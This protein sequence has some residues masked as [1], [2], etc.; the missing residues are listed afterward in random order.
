MGRDTKYKLAKKIARGGMAE[1]FL[2]SKRN[3]DGFLRICCI[4]RIL[5]HFASEKEFTDMFRDEARLC[6]TLS[7]PNIVQVEDFQE[8]D[9]SWAIVMEFVAGSDLRALLAACE[10]SRK[11][12]SIPMICWIGAEAAR[13]LHYAHTRID[14][15]TGKGLGIVHRD[16]SP[17]NLMV[18]FAGD[19]KVTDFGIAEADSKLNET[20]PGIVKGKYAYMSPEQISAKPVDARTDVFALGV[21]LWEAISMRRL[22][23]SDNDA[24]TIDMVK[25]CKIPSVF[26]YN[27]TEDIHPDLKIIIAKALKKD[28]KERW[29]SIEDFEKALRKFIA[30]QYPNFE[31]LELSKFI[32]SIMA[33]KYDEV[34]ENIKETLMASTHENPEPDVTG[35]AALLKDIKP[36]SILTPKE[37]A[38]VEI[39]ESQLTALE[40]KNGA[41]LLTNVNSQRPQRSILDEE[42]STIPKPQFRSSHGG[43]GVRIG[44][45]AS[46][47]SGFASLARLLLACA[48]IFGLT[49]GYMNY[50]NAKITTGKL[51]FSL[52]P[53]RMM[54]TQNKVAL[55]DGDYMLGPSNVELTSGD[56]EYTF[57]REGFESKRLK[58][59]VQPGSVKNVNVVLKKINKSAPV[60]LMTEGNLPITYKFERN[61]A[62]GILQPGVK[63]QVQ[64]LIENKPYPLTLMIKGEKTTSTCTFIP[65]SNN[66]TNPFLVTILQPSLKCRVEAP[67]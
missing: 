36:K 48:G 26:K 34:Q 28:L 32:K 47:V 14:E 23:H 43:S 9:G 2:A 29:K 63:T 13:G 61:L 11:A 39:L 57:S 15:K 22:F 62:S 52:T 6:Q 41:K 3:R 66:W 65:A 27:G 55:G 60:V 38:Q 8:V 7:H 59:K 54:I 40:T 37:P 50:M 30:A 12:L 17:Q 49:L 1:I 5:P 19:I 10:K 56:Y 4:K 46:R 35:Q 51:S 24:T 25:N 67:K 45:K 64:D 44:K 58:V 53:D 42:R 20:K 33:S 21:V 18:S 16:I 31:P